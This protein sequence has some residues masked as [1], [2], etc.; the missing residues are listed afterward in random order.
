VG[1]DFAFDTPGSRRAAILYD[2]GADYNSGLA[3]SFRRQFKAI[4][5]AVVADDAYQ[6]GD[7]DFNAQQP[8]ALVDFLRLMPQK[9]P[10][11]R[12]ARTGGTN[13][14]C[15][16]KNRLKADFLGSYARSA[17][18]CQITHIKAANPDVVYLPNYYNDVALR[19]RQLRAQ[20]VTRAL[21][22]GDGWGDLVDN[23]GDKGA[24][25]RKNRRLRYP[26]TAGS[27]SW[28]KIF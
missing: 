12:T 18:N 8:V 27:I 6:S 22:G 9:I 11:Y 2:A 15:R 10:D 28:L 1:A 16:V 13:A 21:I 4:G 20:G 3:D 23:A 26:R 19:A 25:G 14:V 7:V 17:T 24:E 5:G